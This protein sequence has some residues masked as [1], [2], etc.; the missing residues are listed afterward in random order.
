MIS[1]HLSLPEQI[2]PPLLAWRQRY[3]KERV[4]GV[5][6]IEM[7]GGGKPVLLA[8]MALAATI[9]F[10]QAATHVSLLLGN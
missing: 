2:L 8:T 1:F 6:P 7:V 3:V 5:V 4:D 10:N 9:I